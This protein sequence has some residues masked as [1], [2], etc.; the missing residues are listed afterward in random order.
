MPTAQIFSAE[1]GITRYFGLGDIS[2]KSLLHGWA[3]PEET[4][5]WND[6]YDTSLTIS[7]PNPPETV[8]VLTIEGR[9]HLAPGLSRQDITLFFNGRRLGFWRLDRLEGFHLAA[10]IEPEFWLM[11]QRGVF[12]KCIWHLPDSTRPSAISGIQ[13][14]RLL[15]LCFQ[16]ITIGRKTPK[17]RR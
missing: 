16:S 10:E 17:P 7:L 13:D 15:G 11:R 1:L 4:H 6:G 12:G 3:V 9:P 8:C 2:G 5:N 14:D